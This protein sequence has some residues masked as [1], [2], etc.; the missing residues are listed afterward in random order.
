MKTIIVGF[1]AF[2]PKVYERLAEQGKLPNLGKYMEQGGYA[3]FWVANPPQSEVSWT[4]IAT[5]LNPGKHGLFDF[6]HRNPANYA[7]HVSLLPTERK[8]LGVHFMPPHE[9]PTLFDYAVGQGYPATC[10]W[11]P[12]TFPARLAS[13]VRTLPGLG[14]PDILGRLGVGTF[15]SPDTTLLDEDYKS[16]IAHLEQDGK[17]RYK[18]SLNGPMQKKGSQTEQASL[19]FQLELLDENTG[20]L[21]IGRECITLAKGQWSPILQVSFKVKLGLSVHAITRAILND[22]PS[23]LGLY[24]LPLQIHPLHSPWPYA[25]PRHFVKES[26]EA[27][28]PFLTLGWPQ[29]TTGLEEGFILD[30]QFLALCDSILS[31]REQLFL[32]QVACFKEGVLAAV[33]D[34]LDRVQHMFW[35]D[36]PDVIEGWYEKLDVLLGRIQDQAGDELGQEPRILVVSDHGFADFET[37]VHL[38]RWLI[39]KGYLV[40]KSAKDQGKLEDVDWSRSRAYAIGLTSLYLNQAGREGQGIVQKSDRDALLDRLKS[41]LLQWQGP[42]DRKVVHGVW[43]SEEMYNGPMTEFG[44][45]LVVGFNTGYRASAQTGL[46]GWERNALEPNHDHWG[47]DHCMDP[48]LVPGVIFSNRN[49]KDLSDPSYRDI[50]ELAIG[51]ALDLKESYP[52]KAPKFSDE[53]QQVLEERLKDL[54]YL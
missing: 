6:V 36:R 32:H 47:A 53:D 8:M 42:D 25:T 50:P 2:D 19:D 51:A 54:G 31:S 4:S 37:K 33:F 38:N 23:G 10:L 12:A 44:P 13:P 26:W 16:K 9:A 43:C 34:T 35:R 1:D 21:K 5:G 15:Y 45:D 11:W 40:L 22:H 52:S 46:G 49:L 24:F 27:F 20:R 39:D 29:D 30:D 17:G 3:R 41:E 18:G 14:T 7:L 48:A 28:G